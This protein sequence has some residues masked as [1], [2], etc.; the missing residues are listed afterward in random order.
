MNT[1]IQDAVNLAWKLAADLDG[2]ASGDLLDSYDS[3][4]PPNAAALLAFTEQLTSVA[5][6]RDPAT[7]K[8]RDQALHATAQVKELT[9]FLADRLAQLDIS[10]HPP[11]ASNPLIGTRAVPTGAWATTLNGHCSPPSSSV[12]PARC[13][14]PAKASRSSPDPVPYRPRCSYAPTGTSL[15]PPTTPAH[16][17]YTP[18]RPW[19][20]R[21]RRGAA[22]KRAPVR[23]LSRCLS[24]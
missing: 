15:P 13:R 6:L 11:T 19:P 17:D 12:I 18:W 3:E 4:R 24:G 20:G 10:Y 23:E 14:S 1:G 16:P 7:M 8:L 21:S 5:E 22:G 2:T 9:P